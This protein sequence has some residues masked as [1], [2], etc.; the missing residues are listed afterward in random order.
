MKERNSQVDAFIKNEKKW[1]EEIQLLREIALECDLTEDFKWRLPCYTNSDRNIVIIQNFKNFCALM[2]FDGHRL[3]DPKHLLKSPGENSQT[4]R[5]FE[6]TNVA[7]IKKMKA[8][9]KSY[10]K[11]ALK[12]EGAPAKT[13]KKKPALPAIPAELQTKFKE[14]K[15]LKSAFEAL[16]PGR[17]RHYLMHFSSAKQAATRTSRIEKCIPRILKGLGLND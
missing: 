15:K 7:E 6:F 14:N 13:E 10:I 3:K 4:A 5:R 2:F 11:E 16:T 17:Q 12:A 9:I 1:K 8:A